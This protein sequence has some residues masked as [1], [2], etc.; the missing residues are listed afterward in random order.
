MLLTSIKPEEIPPL[1]LNPCSE[2]QCE[3]FV[4][5]T[6]LFSFKNVIMGSQV[7]RLGIGNQLSRNQA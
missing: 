3:K 2:L 1:T 6:V 4:Q 7:Q 5:W